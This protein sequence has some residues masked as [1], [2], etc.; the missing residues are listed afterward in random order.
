MAD[1]AGEMETQADHASD[2]SVYGDDCSFDAVT[3]SRMSYTEADAADLS[4]ERICG[5]LYVLGVLSE[6]LY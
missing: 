2:G 4:S 1:E 6:E 5:V 3:A